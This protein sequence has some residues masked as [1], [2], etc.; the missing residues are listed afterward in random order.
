MNKRPHITSATKFNLIEAFL[1]I[2]RDK[3]GAKVTV[4]DV[5]NKS[6]YNRTTLYRYF[7]SMK[8]LCDAANLWMCVE[9]GTNQRIIRN[10]TQNIDKEG[11]AQDA[12]NIVKA[13]YKRIGLLRNLEE[14]AKF[15]K[16]F[17][18]FTMMS[19]L[20]AN[21]NLAKGHEDY[22]RLLTH[23]H[24]SGTANLF[25]EYARHPGDVSMEDFGD[26]FAQLHIDGITV[27]LH[28]L[29]ELDKKAPKTVV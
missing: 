18:E 29:N 28:K 5:V 17:I 8:Q 20:K 13:N 11:M 7:R 6:G 10:N 12:I 19:Y 23:Y 1:V 27:L 14:E 3:N 24:L 4:E 15:K 21:K 2:A 22:F 16:D 26:L 25:V 9:T